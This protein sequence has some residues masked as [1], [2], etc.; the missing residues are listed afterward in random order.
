MRRRGLRLAA[1][2]RAIVAAPEEDEVL[3]VFES[4]EKLADEIGRLL[5]VIRELAGARYACLIEP[6]ATLFESAEDEGWAISALRDFLNARRGELFA[7]PARLSAHE[8]FEDPFADSEH[9]GF[10]LAVLNGRVALVLA[11]PEPAAVEARVRRPLRVLADR[12]LRFNQAYRIDQ[13]GFGFLFGSPRLETVV[14]EPP[15]DRD[16]EA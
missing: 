14:V 13:K 9:D 12:L 15:A 2:P 16:N 11:C 4:S 7:L 8:P 1:A 10:F 3:G 5:A 6:D